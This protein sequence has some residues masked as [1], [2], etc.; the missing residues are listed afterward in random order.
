[1]GTVFLARQIEPVF[2]LATI[3]DSLQPEGLSLDSDQVCSFLG[4][5]PSAALHLRPWMAEFGLRIRELHREG[6][7]PA[8]EERNRPQM[9]PTV[10]SCLALVHLPQGPPGP[11]GPR[12]E[13][14]IEFE[15]VT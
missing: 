12:G 14:G 2:E 8:A 5:S 11:A 13:P 1:M 10:D 9:R 7:W 4:S 15:G 3:P 6:D